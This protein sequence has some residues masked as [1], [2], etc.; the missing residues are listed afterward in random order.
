MEDWQAKQAAKA[1]A[2]EALRKMMPAIRRYIDKGIEPGGFLAAVICNDLRGAVGRAD[3]ENL[4]QL[5]AFVSYF[6]NDAPS[7]CWGSPEKFEA[8]LRRF[9]EAAP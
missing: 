3:A 2:A 1:A 5:P 9:E 7:S 4:S 6:Y 8:W